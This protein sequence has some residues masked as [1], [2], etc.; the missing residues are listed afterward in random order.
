LA[1][2]F[3]VLWKEWARGKEKELTEQ[4]E[5]QVKTEQENLQKKAQGKKGKGLK[6][7]STGNGSKE[8]TQQI[9]EG[10]MGKTQGKSSTPKKEEKKEEQIDSSVYLDQ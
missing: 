4:K 3:C 10:S 7:Q 9:S 6:G 8:R 1:G 2:D 5:V